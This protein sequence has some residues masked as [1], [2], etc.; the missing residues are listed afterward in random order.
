MDAWKLLDYIPKTN[1][2]HNFVLVNIIL[3][4][5]MCN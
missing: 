1:S 4:N 2:F 5:A 3:L